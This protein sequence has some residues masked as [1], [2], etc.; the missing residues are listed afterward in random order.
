MSNLIK[1]LIFQSVSKLG[2]TKQETQQ[3]RKH[4]LQ[5]KHLHRDQSV[6]RAYIFDLARTHMESDNND[7][8]MNWMETSIKI[9]MLKEKDFEELNEVY[10][11]PGNTCRDAIIGQIEN[12]RHSIK[13][14]V[15]T[16]SDNNIAKALKSAHHRGISIKIISDNDKCNDRGSDVYELADNKIPV[17]I[18]HSHHHMHHK[19]AIFDDE[20]LLTGSYNWTMSAAQYNQENILLTRNE[21]SIKAYR[22]EFDRLWEEMDQVRSYK[23]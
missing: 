18:D 12:A 16:I 4:L 19:F 8:L 1:P 20:A 6:L 11:S 3:I 22:K 10:F 21:H 9:I 2:Y 14:C 23:L 13:V 15:F 5:S 17:K 7:R